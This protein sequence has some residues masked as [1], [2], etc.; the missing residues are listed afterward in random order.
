MVNSYLS[1]FAAIG[2]AYNK[3]VT[4]F[5]GKKISKSALEE[6]K[7]EWTNTIKDLNFEAYSTSL[8][9]EGYSLS[10]LRQQLEAAKTASKINQASIQNIDLK[11]A[12][13]QPGI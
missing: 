12:N 5:N 1:S 8:D 11:L 7:Q 6:F 13:L 4:S 2:T 9:Q 3:L 10:Q